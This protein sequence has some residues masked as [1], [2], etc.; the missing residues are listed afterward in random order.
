M[1]VTVPGH[2]VVAIPVEVGPGGHVAP[3]VVV[4]EGIGHRAQGSRRFADAGRESRFYNLVVDHPP[5]VTLPGKACEEVE[6]QL[7]SSGYPS[8]H[9]VNPAVVIQV[10]V[11]DGGLEQ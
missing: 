11:S 10:G 5:T 1:P 2:T 9:I 8:G 7:V 6:E 4:R 3:V